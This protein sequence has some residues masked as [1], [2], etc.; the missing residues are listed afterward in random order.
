MSVE[1]VSLQ[2]ELYRR[3]EDKPLQVDDLLDHP[4][5]MGMTC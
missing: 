4:A 2:T 1:A 5:R 3:E